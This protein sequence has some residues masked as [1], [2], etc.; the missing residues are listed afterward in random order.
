MEAA[1][2]GDLAGL[3]KRTAAS[4]AAS[5]GEPLAWRCGRPFQKKNSVSAAV[6][7]PLAC[8]ES[9]KASPHNRPVPSQR[10]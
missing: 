2:H 8:G 6:S 10:L 1:E 7:D 5:L 4:G 9:D 3:I